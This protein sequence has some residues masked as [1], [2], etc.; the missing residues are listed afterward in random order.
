MKRKRNVKVNMTIKN[1]LII[2]FLAILILP[3][4]AIGWFSYQKAENQI[5]A[6]IEQNALQS[7]QSV[8]SEIN[9]LFS[10]S[11]S[12]LDYL[13]KTVNGNM[14]KGE[15]SPELRKV[16]EP[17]KAVKPEYDHVQFAT[18]SGVL[19]NSPQQKFE[20]GFD[21]RERPWYSLAIEKK[22]T[23]LVNNPIVAQDGKVIVVPSKATEDGSG[24]VSVVLSL[25]NLS[26]QV[27]NIKVGEKG[28]ISILD[29]DGKYLTHPAIA[30][31]T[32]SKESFVPKFYEKDSGTIDYEGKNERI[33]F[34]TNELT[35]WKIAGTIEMEE[36]T[37]ATQGI[38]YTT[39]AVIVISI[40]IGILLVFWIVRSI[41]S[42]LKDLKEAMKE[43]ASGNLTYEL[44]SGRKDEIGEIFNHLNDTSESLKKVIGK[45]SVN[46]ELI[47]TSSVQLSASSDQTSQAAE[48][49]STTISEVAAGTERQSKS[50]E[51]ATQIVNEM[52]YGVQQITENARS[53]SINA[54]NTADKAGT[55]NEAIQKTIEQMS[56]IQTTVN[57]L[58]DEVKG[59]GGQSKQIGDIIQTITDISG[60][61]NLLA[62]NAA[63]EAARA[64]EYGKGFAVVAD[65]VRKL[66]EQSAASAEQITQL[67]SQNQHQT[68]AAVKTMEATVQEVRAGIELVNTAGQSFKEI[69]TAT[70]DVTKQ[71]EEVA[72]AIQQ[73]ADSANMIVTSINVISE[74]A[75]DTVT[76]THNVSASTQEQL[77][78]L[79]EVS[80]SAASLST[81][82]EELQGLIRNFKI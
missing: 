60:Q 30:A 77:A 55:G 38:L 71:T 80:A 67:I 17:I 6:E 69:Q 65:E 61:T 4:S 39:I 15:A 7:V 44:D 5:A 34:V 10:T 73:I 29:K 63:I 57:S 13:S 62:L 66:A 14:V 35:G 75:V 58:A 16:L 78:S 47:S 46:S 37:N 3:S 31:G 68:D 9:E 82:A 26:E 36:I 48:H 43:I 19:L 49:I 25:T 79:E 54:G 41:T 27:N 8:N 72:S 1:R 51:Q 2:A 56:A 33:V 22:G 18:S 21:P 40:L 76:G 32:E 50:V 64:G 53:V 45:I 52:S 23:A 59:L 70:D 42:P 11:L 74:V 81:M 20:A 12:D 28:F 24:V